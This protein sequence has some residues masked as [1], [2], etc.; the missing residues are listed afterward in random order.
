[1]ILYQFQSVFITIPFIILLFACIEKYL[2]VARTFLGL[3]STYNPYAIS[4]VLVQ[5]N[6]LFLCFVQVLSA[7]CRVYQEVSCGKPLRSWKQVVQSALCVVM[8]GLQLKIPQ[9]CGIIC[10]PD[11]TAGSTNWIANRNS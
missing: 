1:M 11:T 10:V 6:Y 4:I 8:W 5:R 9:T 3:Y 7:T 2:L